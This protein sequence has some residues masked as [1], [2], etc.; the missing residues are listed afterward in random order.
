MRT[1]K[2][3]ALD[4]T[5]Q[6]SVHGALNGAA[7]NTVEV[8]MVVFSIFSKVMKLW[9]LAGRRRWC[10][11]QD[12]KLTLHMLWGLNTSNATNGSTHAQCPDGSLLPLLVAN[13]RPSAGRWSNPLA[14]AA[15]TQS[16]RVVGLLYVIPIC[17]ESTLILLAMFYVFSFDIQA[18][19]A[20]AATV[21]LLYQKWSYKW[22]LEQSSE[23][24]FS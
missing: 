6:S 9:A 2:L 15:F 13:L 17:V 14:P 5:C 7:V 21:T 20:G 22:E 12:K 24:T 11:L 4:S 18:A 10:C 19:G 3:G 1:T 16:Q 23:L 8:C